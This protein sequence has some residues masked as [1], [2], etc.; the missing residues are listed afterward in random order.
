MFDE[1]L[2]RV[3]AMRKRWIM[4]AELRWLGGWWYFGEVMAVWQYVD[5]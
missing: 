1:S 5:E 4:G 3:L 2:T